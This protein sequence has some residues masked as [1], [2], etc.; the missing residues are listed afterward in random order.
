MKAKSSSDRAKSST[1]AQAPATAQT[2]STS[3]NTSS[4]PQIEPNENS[5]PSDNCFINFAGS[6]HAGKEAESPSADVPVL[7]A[8]EQ[9]A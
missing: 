9:Q 6:S 3:N 2:S 1:V 4:V 8:T 5:D 7:P